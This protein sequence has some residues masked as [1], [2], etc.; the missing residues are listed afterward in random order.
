MTHMRQA[1]QESHLVI[2]TSLRNTLSTI[3]SPKFSEVTVVYREPDFNI[4]YG[5]LPP[6]RFNSR[7][8]VPSSNR[9]VFEM[10][11]K[12]QEIRDFKPVLCANVWGHLEE[13]VV[14]ELEW[15]VDTVWA[16][17][18]RDMVSSRPLVISSPRAFLPAPCEVY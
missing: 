8:E 10:L 18:G 9:M 1:A 14:R 16:E 4:A 17:G 2:T 13:F 6:V 15:L 7:E 12:M 11:R 5:L 3:T